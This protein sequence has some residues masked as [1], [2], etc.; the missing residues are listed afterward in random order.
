MSFSSGYSG[1]ECAGTGSL[2]TYKQS[3]AIADEVP[4]RAVSCSVQHRLIIWYILV[5]LDNMICT[6][7]LQQQYDRVW[8]CQ[9]GSPIYFFLLVG[10]PD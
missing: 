3:C 5:V 1:T 9:P 7:I 6:A 4:E 8:F 10:E 2:E